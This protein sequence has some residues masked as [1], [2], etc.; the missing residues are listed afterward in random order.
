ME[1]FDQIRQKFFESLQEYGV[2]A[3][4]VQQLD[5]F[6]SDLGISPE[7]LVD[8]LYR[9]A[10]MQ[11]WELTAEEVRALAVKE[12]LTVSDMDDYLRDKLMDLG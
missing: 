4:D 7:E 5:E 1:T 12:D 11:N 6:G 2:E 3:T 8:A 9:F 10:Q